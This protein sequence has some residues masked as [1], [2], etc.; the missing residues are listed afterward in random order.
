VFGPNGK[1]DTVRRMWNLATSVLGIDPG[2]VWV[3]YFEGGDVLGNR[4]PADEE[5]Y[6]AWRKAGVPENRLVG[7]GVEDNYWVQGG[8]IDGMEAP[9]K[10][11][12]N[13][14]L[15]YDRG[16]ERACGRD[17]KPGCRCGRFVEFSNSLFIWGQIDAQ[18]ETIHPLSD[19]FSE[20][21]IGTER[22]EMITQGA[23]SV[24]DTDGY[25]AI[26]EGIRRFR[27]RPGLPDGLAS[28]SERVI[29]DYLKALYVLVADGAPAPGKNGRERIVKL[30]I[31]GVITHQIVL[32][33]E[34]ELLLPEL[35]DAISATVD[36]A[37]RAA[38]EDKARLLSYFSAESLRFSKTLERGQR[39][40]RQF[41]KKNHGATLSGPQIVQL[42]K[43][44]GLP[45]L[46]T[47]NTLR[48]RGLPF[49]EAEYRQALGAW[50]QVPRN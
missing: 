21:V 6:R 12:P 17:C 48:E 14:E 42:E 8:G 19:P 16:A 31:R 37:V 43:K 30:L 29:A 38:P 5:T 4:M 27:Y 28:H 47:A 11:G 33:I 32:G 22:V 18:D 36:G 20:T 45:H 44:W 13:T 9:R 24:F 7:L 49:L 26:I 3:S 39:Q 40:L 10:C 23:R 35:L 25:R 50:K 15:F 2:R 1:A 34:R 46:L 41:L